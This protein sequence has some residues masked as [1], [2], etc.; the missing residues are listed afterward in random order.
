MQD[1][2]A[3]QPAAERPPEGLFSILPPI[4]G[5]ESLA[6]RLM[7]RCL[8]PLEWVMGLPQVERAY[9]VASDEVRGQGAEAFYEAYLRHERIVCDVSESDLAKVPKTGPLLVVANHPFGTVDGILLVH[10]LTRVRKDVRMWANYLLHRIPEVRE[11][12]FFVNPFETGTAARENIQS[13]RNGMEWLRQGG[14]M[15][16]FPAG[17]VSHFDWKTRTVTDP[18][19]GEKAARLIRKTAAP[20]LPVYI[21]GH[22]SW[23]FQVAGMIHPLLRTALLF[24][25][26]CNKVGRTVPIRIGQ[27]VSCKKLSL[28]DEDRRMIAYLRFRSYLMAARNRDVPRETVRPEVMEPVDPPVDPAV[29]AAEVAA[30]PPEQVLVDSPDSLVCWA[31]AAQIPDLLR[32]IGRLRELTFRL[33]GEGTGNRSD[34]DRFDAS[35]LH[36]FIWNRPKSELVGA[37]R[38]GQTD[39]ILPRFGQSGLYTAT[40]FR[41]NRNMLKRISPALEMGRSFVRP[42]YQKNYAPLLLLWKGI[43]QFIVRN[44][45][46]K[47]LFGPVSIS[48]RYQSVSRLLMMDFLEANNFVT[49]LSKMVSAKVP[50]RAK[51]VRFWDRHEA[52]SCISSID[53]LSELVA[54]IETELKEIPILLKQYLRLGGKLL[55]FNLDPDFHDVLDGLILVD[56]TQSEPRTL[57]RYLGKDGL[58]EFLRFHRIPPA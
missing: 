48:N 12:A 54:D 14:V 37:Y 28:F 11:H 7:R 46:Y 10:L 30:L 19:W 50:L 49:D 31:G 23:L 25:E 58:Q 18:E 8:R 34:L 39:V 4:P 16:F 20:V 13:L 55:G 5:A 27:P 41:F 57:E 1:N 33:A 2:A 52:L 6:R 17:T 24:R 38:L 22:N 36:L 32:E 51:S 35:Y 29:L 44:P 9:F 45:R 3:A 42:E 21:E 15:I 47:I 53:D 43:G 26:L 40:L 56:L